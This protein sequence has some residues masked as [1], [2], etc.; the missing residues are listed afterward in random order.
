VSEPTSF[1]INFF[2]QGDCN[3]AAVRKPSGDGFAATTVLASGSIRDVAPL[4]SSLRRGG[5][6]DVALTARSSWFVFVL[7]IGQ[8]SA[9]NQGI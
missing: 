7:E 5:G 2:F 3:N 6:L 4:H 9:A 8:N 1:D